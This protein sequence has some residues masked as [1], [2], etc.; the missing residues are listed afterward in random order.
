M[1]SKVKSK[2]L[3]EFGFLIAFGFPLIIGWI[4]PILSGHVF[5][6]WTLWIGLPALISAI[7]SPKLLYYPY[8]AWMKIGYIL[9]WI[10]SRII[11][12]VLFILVLLPISLIMRFFNYDPLRLNKKN[13]L[14]YRETI[15]DKKISLNRIF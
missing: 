15:K 12:G 5:R 4:M 6:I 3:R 8:Q 13:E 1:K 14:S 7:F 11:L 2:Q 10:N 9:G